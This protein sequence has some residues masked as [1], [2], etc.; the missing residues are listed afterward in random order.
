MGIYGYKQNLISRILFIIFAI[1]C[2]IVAIIQLKYLRKLK[3]LSVY[4]LPLLSISMCYENILL[5][6]SDQIKSNSIESEIGK[7]LFS[8]QI[9]LFLLITFEVPCRLHEARSVQFFLVPFDQEKEVSKLSGEIIIIIM[10]L[11][12]I[13]AL[14][15]N[16]FVNFSNLCINQLNNSYECSLPLRSGYYTLAYHSN[17]I[18][19]WIALSVPTY[20]FIIT[21]NIYICLYRY[22]KNATLSLTTNTAWNT[23]L[24]TSLCQI[25]SQ[26]FGT[27]IYPVASNAGEILLLL[28]ICWLVYL[29]QKDLSIT[30]DFAEFLHRSNIAFK[31]LPNNIQNNNS[32]Q[33][34][35]HHHKIKQTEIIQLNTNSTINNNE[36]KV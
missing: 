22:N 34:H 36:T 26:I 3:I 24:I 25:L 7:V 19:L 16:L 18:M 29:V 20:L 31:Q 35:H 23:I 27:T 15:L 33:H 13:G 11:L 8:L 1:I 14:I 10:R 6:L 9:P 28:G 12:A 2:L 4:L 32:H 21:F 5:F 17:N 30:R